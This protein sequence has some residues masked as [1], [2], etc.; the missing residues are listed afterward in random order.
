MLQIQSTITSYFMSIYYTHNIRILKL[1]ILY[2]IQWLIHINIVFK[3]VYVQCIDYLNY[4]QNHS[5]IS[6]LILHVLIILECS[7]FQFPLKLNW[8]HI[9]RRCIYI[10]G[11]WLFVDNINALGQFMVNTRLTTYRWYRGPGVEIFLTL[12]KTIWCSRILVWLL[13]FCWERSDVDPCSVF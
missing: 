7:T 5:I 6:D 12:S 3:Y 10:Y 1:I 2:F 4:I 8:L 9:Y 11:Y 13:T